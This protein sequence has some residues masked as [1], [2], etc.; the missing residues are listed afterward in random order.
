MQSIFIFLFLFT[1]INSDAECPFVKKI[2]ER[3]ENKNTLRLVQYNA[4]CL[5]ID[6]YSIMNCSGHSCTWKNVSE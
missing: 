1:Y 4:E 3:R 6:Y 5:F 2:E